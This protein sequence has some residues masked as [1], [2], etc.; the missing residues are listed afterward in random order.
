MQPRKSGQPSTSK[1]TASRNAQ[2]R[3]HAQESGRPISVTPVEPAAP[4]SSQNDISIESKGR[5]DD[6]GAVDTLKCQ[7]MSVATLELTGIKTPC[8][9]STTES[10]TLLPSLALGNDLV[11][12]VDKQSAQNGEEFQEE[13]ELE[14]DSFTSGGDIETQPPGRLSGSTILPTPKTTR[15]ARSPTSAEQSDLDEL[16]DSLSDIPFAMLGAAERAELLF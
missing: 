8:A 15:V 16:D 2:G 4:C 6:G 12:Q 11:A 14:S 3:K 5:K 13:D 7:S 9:S 10:F 1:S